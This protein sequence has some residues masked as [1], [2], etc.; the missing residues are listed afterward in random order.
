MLDRPKDLALQP[1]VIRLSRACS[2]AFGHLGCFADVAVVLLLGI[3]DYYVKDD[4]TYES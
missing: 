2:R 1:C 4:P 3:D